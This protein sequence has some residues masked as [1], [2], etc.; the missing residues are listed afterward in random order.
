MKYTTAFYFCVSIFILWR[1]NKSSPKKVCVR[2]C[3]CL[4][5]CVCLC[6]CA[7]VCACVCICVCVL[8][9]LCLCVCLCVRTCD[10]VCVCVS[11]CVCVCLSTASTA[12]T[13][14]RASVYRVSP[15]VHGRLGGGGARPTC[16]SQM[17]PSNQFQESRGGDEGET[18]AIT[19]APVYLLSP[20]EMSGY[21][22]TAEPLL[23]VF[24]GAL[25]GSELSC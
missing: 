3:L 13:R 1:K 6:L 9:F 11:A 7:S 10:C 12:V 15:G 21:R 8:F 2:V 25:G 5:L 4:W 18:R 20:V 16:H 14:Q 19:G 17:K 22:H 23:S 24:I